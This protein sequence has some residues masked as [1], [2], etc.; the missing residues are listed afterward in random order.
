MPW[1]ES[2]S[3]ARM[4]R[5]ALVVPVESCR[6]MLADVALSAAVELD[7]PY[8]PGDG[9][10]EVQRAADSA[11]VSGPVAGLV[12]WVPTRGLPAL[13]ATLAPLG[14]GVVPLAHPRG[15][16]PPT[17]LTGPGRAR[18]SRTLV[19]TYGTVPYADVDPSRLAALAYVVMFGMMFGDV[20]H[21]VI[22]VLVGLLLRSGRVSRLAK[23]E[24]AWR[25]V[26]GAGLVSVV[27]GALYGEAF[28]PTGLVPV[29]WLEPL[30][31]PVPLML[32]ALI[33]GA[34]MLAGA[35]AL[36]TINR[37]R[38]GGWGYALYARSGI[39]GSLLFLAVGLLAWGLISDI[40]PVLV[41]GVGLAATALAFIFIG[42]LV[43]AGGGATGVFQ[44]IVEGVDTVIRLGS[45]VVSFAR[46]AAFGLTHA[47]LLTVVWNGT[48]G[49]WA[50]DWHALPAIAVFLVGNALT[51]A[52]EA[53]VAG[54]Q[55]LRLEY[56]EL[57]SR[58][59]QSEGRPF[60]PW[61]PLLP[62]AGPPLGVAG[63]SPDI[64]SSPEGRHP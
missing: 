13:T 24:R 54:I 45:N 41:T 52:L 39:A 34:A 17:L 49:L 40:R 3:P 37:V 19:D 7:L 59:F 47:A 35:Y 61:K 6:E 38:E 46:L 63:P 64:P 9:P 50:P 27:F 51:F 32:T 5:V 62:S 26:T 29:L 48:T 18:L 53:L 58:I 21:G 1:R 31:S 44:A 11:V 33:I 20:G 12:G 30:S 8:A 55:A 16:Q 22:L 15:V 28:G 56:Y 60:R 43:D 42:L 14:A 10:A 23:L 57:F 2:L 36:G 4:E 25:F